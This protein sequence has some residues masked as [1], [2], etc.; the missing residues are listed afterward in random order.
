MEDNKSRNSKNIYSQ[1][2]D[3]S[4]MKIGHE[5]KMNSDVKNITARNLTGGDARVLLKG[6]NGKIL[7]ENFID[8]NNSGNK[9]L[10]TKFTY[11]GGDLTLDLEH[12][13]VGIEYIVAYSNLKLEE[14]E[15]K[16][17]YDAN[18]TDSIGSV[19]TDNGTYLKDSEIK[20][21]DNEGNLKREGYEFKGW[22]LNPNDTSIVKEFEIKNDTT[23]Y[24][25]WRKLGPGNA[26]LSKSVNTTKVKRGDELIYTIN[27]END[28]EMALKNLKI[29]DEVPSQL[30]NVKISGIDGLSVSNNKISGNID[31]EPKENAVLIVRGTVKDDA[32]FEN[33]INTV[34]AIDSEGK[35]TEAKSEGTTVE[36]RKGKLEITKTPNKEQA[37]IGSELIYMVTIENTG[38]SKLENVRVEDDVPDF[39]E[40]VKVVGDNRI[41][42]TDNRIEGT[43]DLDPGEFVAI[44]IS[45]KV[46]KDASLVGRKFSNTIKA[47]DS[48]GEHSVTTGETEIIEKEEKLIITKN[49]DKE[50]AHPG[51]ELT[52]MITLENTGDSSLTG[53]EIE[54]SA[55]AGLENITVKNAEGNSVD[56]ITVNGNEIKGSI[57][58]ASGESVTLFVCGLVS[59]DAEIGKII[60]NEVVVTNPENGDKIKKESKGTKILLKTDDLVIAKTVDKR[61]VTRGEELKY[62]IVM[63]NTG[64]QDLVNL[65]VSDIVPEYL[66]NIDIEGTDKLAVDG[67]KISGKIDIPATDIFIIIVTGTVKDDAQLNTPFR[68]KVVVTNPNDTDNSKEAYSEDTI[69]IPKDGK[70]A[71][72]KNLGEEEVARG[73]SVTYTITVSNEGESILKGVKIKDEVPSQLENVTVTGAVGITA[74]GNTISGTLDIQPGQDITL[75]VKATVK[76]DAE[77]YSS[78]KN[79]ATA[80]DPEKPDV[81]EE[82]TSEEG[83]IVPKDELP[84]VT[85][86]VDKKE[87]IKGDELSYR[88]TVKNDSEAKQ[89]GIEILDEVPDGLEDITITAPEGVTLT[90]NRVSGK[91]DI[92][93]GET[94]T[95]KIKGKIKSDCELHIFGNTVRVSNPKIP[96]AVAE[97]SSGETKILETYKLIYDGNSNTSGTVPV[98]SKDYI[99]DEEATISGNTGKLEKSGYEFLGWSTNKDSKTAEYKEGDKLKIDKDTTLYAVWTKDS[100]GGSG[101]GGTGTITPPTTKRAIA[102]LANGKKYTD[103]LTATVLAN[104]RDC[105]ILLTGKDS[106]SAE[107]L[108]ELKRRGIGDIIISGGYDS[109]SKKVEEQLKGY[110]LIR[111]SG[112]DRYETARE[113]GKA[114]RSLTGNNDGSMLVDGTN[115]PD[116]ITISALATQKR[117]PILI[118]NPN[119]LTS[120]TENTLKDWKVSDVIIGG[121]VNSVSKSIQD[122]LSS[123]LGIKS[124]SRIGG[125]DRYETASL[126]GVE[127]RKITGNTK[128]MILVDGT[129][130]PDGITINSLAAKFKS[131]IHLTNPNKLTDITAKD[132]ANWKVENILIGGGERSVSK[133]IYDGLNI[134]KKERVSGNDRYL[135]AVKISQKLDY[136]SLVK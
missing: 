88:I 28:G 73:E 57:N 62:A 49:V 136:S 118:T 79:K 80:I 17:K 117:V 64:E 53:V 132:I 52:Y 30:T 55:P 87:A 61:K 94:I 74:S 32:N 25:V 72:H 5:Y 35:I 15:Y 8:K 109:V 16:V 9:N 6:N 95:I 101:G 130:F 107:T 105:P 93:P 12:W 37:T 50:E 24:A 39:L 111:Y 122:R 90:E 70:L 81:V 58:L 131:P 86:E 100:S 40:A 82:A 126:I 69:V 125:A 44:G 97:K 23:L 43:L 42:A 89:T 112:E 127:V 48:N 115:F 29:E 4:K 96:D 121:S 1:K 134:S 91:V 104:E 13:S 66:T 133:D 60:K 99:R 120:T 103:V 10:E 11:T 84:V 2:I 102:V 106:V 113:I 54:D 68:N 67:N 38:E 71:I 85:K 45:G 98:D 7:H 19:P 34:K 47:T 56:G 119:K 46:K 65:D 18:A 26:V 33:F 59:K 51:D 83:I 20:V 110:N 75:I 116:V 129:D 92:E 124:V 31:L 108:N 14:V 77:L 36:P 123:D 63:L 78:F 76:K 22:S 135:T 3:T 41:S 27:V 21:K 114:V 128:D